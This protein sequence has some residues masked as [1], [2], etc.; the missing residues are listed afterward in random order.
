MK[1]G[2]RSFLAFAIGG[3]AGTAL[4]PLPWKLTDDS[5]IWSQ[6]WPWTPVPKDGAVSFVNTVCTLCPGGCGIRVRKV[7]DRIVKVDGMPGHPVND[8]GICIKGLAAAQLLYSPSRIQNPMKR[9][10]DRWQKISW[11][12]AIATVVEKLGALRAAGKPYALGC[13]AGKTQGTAARLLER[14]MLAYGTPNLMHTPSMQDNLNLTAQLMN[15]IQDSSVGFDLDHSDLVLSFGSGLL[16]GWGAPVRAFQAH[17]RLNDRDGK[18]IQIESR[19]SRTAAKADQWIPIN[20]GTQWV[21]AMGIAHVLVKE[22]LYHAEFV[23]NYTEGFDDWKRVVLQRFSPDDVAKATG[24]DKYTTVKLAEAFSSAQKPLAICGAGRGLVPGGI[25]E[26][27]AVHSL[28][29]LAGNINK[30]GGVWSVNQPEYPEWNEAVL[31]Q[32]ASNGLQQQRLDGAGSDKF[33]DAISLLNRLPEAVDA[34]TPYPLEALMVVDA[35][36]VY[37]LQDVQ[38]TKAAFEKIPFIVSCSSFMDETAA[39]ADLVLPDSFFLERFEDVPVADGMNRPILGL[40]KPVI[41]PLFNTRPVGDV[42]IEIARGLGGPIADAFPWDSF[43]VCLEETLSQRHDWAS[44]NEEV[45]WV[46]NDF[47]PRSWGEGFETDSGRFEFPNAAGQPKIEFLPVEVQGDPAAYPLTLMAYDSMRL[48]GGAVA[49]T[50]FMMK[51][52]PDTT[53]K[54][55]DGF[56]EI[57]PLTAKSL[58]LTQGAYASLTTPIGQATVRVNLSEGIMPGV[59]AMV[60]G[61]GRTAFD[62]FI[63]GKGVNVNDLIGP[64]EDPTTG[65]DAAWGI[66][67]KLAKA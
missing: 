41:E 8:G 28:N 56:I 50:P 48:S 26:F 35:N 65:L 23:N 29:A 20:P 49:S 31:D 51:T 46:D 2:R 9:V 38:K 44:L 57:N 47:A 1:V 15:G 32:V 3:A 18:L 62:K 45:F 43:D 36:P 17:S 24:V 55:N 4:T 12:E 33:P 27:M 40:A 30:P 52:V 14:L 10:G 63:R 67:A 21:L 25:H 22:N 61:L 11:S 66:K 60:R 39:M 42:I 5:S 7:D 58:G 16:D 37:T 13:I 34:G 19:L 53:L 6:N 64:V 59:V 54:K